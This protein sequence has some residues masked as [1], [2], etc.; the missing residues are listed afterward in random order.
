MLAALDAARG[1]GREMGRFHARYDLLLTSTTGTPPPRLGGL[2]PT[3]GEIR[4]LA[5]LARFP[6]RPLLLRALH[7]MGPEALEALPNTQ[8]FNLTGQPAASVPMGWTDDGL[9][10]GVQLV[11]AVGDEARILQVAAQLERARPWTDRLPPVIRDGATPTAPRPTG[12][13]P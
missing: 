8:V 2:G 7:V 9:P 11:A 10:L 13:T 3:P 1:A 6:L 5:T 4:Q 12:A